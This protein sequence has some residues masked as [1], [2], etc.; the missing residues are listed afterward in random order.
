MFKK[1]LKYDMKATW[2]VWWILIP[3]LF[4]LST[5]FALSLR[6]ITET[7]EQE[8]PHVFT[9]LLSLLS[10]LFMSIAYIGFFGSIVMTEVLV[11]VRFY[12]N[13]FTDEGYLTFTLPVS[14]PTILL[15]KTVNAPNW[16]SWGT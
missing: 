10:M 6:I 3:S 7:A 5:L 4:G 2:R 11:F 15:S 8:N 9:I 12:K 16:I 1:L 13:L 14:R